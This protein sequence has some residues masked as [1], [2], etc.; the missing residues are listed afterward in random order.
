MRNLKVMGPLI[1]IAI[2]MSLI[3][4]SVYAQDQGAS[5]NPAEQDTLDLP[6][7]EAAPS[8]QPSQNQSGDQAGQGQ[9]PQ[10][11]NSAK[12]DEDV[13]QPPPTPPQEPFVPSQPTPGT[14]PG[15]ETMNAPFVN[16]QNGQD[17][18]FAPNGQTPEG[19][20]PDDELN[21]NAQGEDT[22]VPME[23]FTEDR[24]ED[25]F[26]RRMMELNEEVL[27]REFYPIF[28]YED[29]DRR[30]PFMP[31]LQ[32]RQSLDRRGGGPSGLLQYDLTQ[33]SLTAIAWNTKEPK[34]LIRDPKANI[35]MVKKKDPIGRNNGYVEDIREGEII[36]IES[37]AV[38]GGQ[39]FYS[40]QILRV[41][42]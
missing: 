40:T 42:R 16:N 4:S 9:A 19:V 12:Q 26:A 32:S 18:D 5:T 6:P 31:I 11:S 2:G 23:E 7:G 28:I 34:A 37:R 30:D 8:Q 25:E 27:N 36:V 41:G 38:K 10:N 13:D 33:L 39:K 35:Y 15:R 22:P 20:N 21:W 17:G 14:A 1:A 24:L 3:L 29:R